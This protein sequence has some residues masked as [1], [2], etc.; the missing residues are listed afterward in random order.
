MGHTTG[1]QFV[2]LLLNR[3]SWLET[4]WPVG[5]IHCRRWRTEKNRAHWALMV[6]GE[7]RWW[8]RW[9]RHSAPDRLGLRKP[10]DFERQT[11]PN[12][13][14]RLLILVGDF[15]KRASFPTGS[16]HL[17]HWYV[18]PRPWSTQVQWYL[19]V[20]PPC[21]GISRFPTNFLLI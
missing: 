14:P 12:L 6:E 10:F 13:G 18:E 7:S 20:A 2:D 15:V 4:W 11:S 5:P 17:V 16:H 19:L 21:S 8:R 9:C 3:K 1:G